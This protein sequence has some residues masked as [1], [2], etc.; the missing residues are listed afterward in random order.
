MDRLLYLMRM[1]KAAPVLRQGHPI[2]RVPVQKVDPKDIL[3]SSGPTHAAVQAMRSVFASPYH[4][5]IGLSAPQV[6]HSLSIIAYR[7]NT[8]LTFLFNPVLAPLQ[9]Q[10]KWAAQYESCESLPHYNCIV[11]RPDRV[12]VTA[13]DTDANEVSFEASG[14]LARVIHHECDHL[15]GITLADRMVEKTL[16]HDQYIDVFENYPSSNTHR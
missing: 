2:L 4:S 16:R 8:P 7:N 15:E 3:A 13:L 10:S 6:G 5:V 14:F 12:R 11:R 1:K 9:P